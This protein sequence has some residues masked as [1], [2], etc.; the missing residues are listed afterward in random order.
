MGAN[1]A[2][3]ISE[4]GENLDADRMD[5]SPSFVSYIVSDVV[6]AVGI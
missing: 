6:A 3:E 1:S 4:G 5:S 2:D